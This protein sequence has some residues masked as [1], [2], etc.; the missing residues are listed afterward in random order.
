M[1]FAERELRLDPPGE[2]L[3]LDGVRAEHVDHL[4]A[5]LQNSDRLAIDHPRAGAAPV[6]NSSDPHFDLL[7]FRW[8]R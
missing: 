6:V 2:P 3:S 8:A 5:V 7:G 4:D 1:R